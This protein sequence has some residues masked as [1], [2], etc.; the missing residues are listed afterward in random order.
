MTY[1]FDLV[2]FVDVRSMLAKGWEPMPD[3][4]PV[5]RYVN[6]EITQTYVWM[7]KADEPAS[8]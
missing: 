7:R 6:R 1:S 8:H 2:A 3:M 5:Y 4:E